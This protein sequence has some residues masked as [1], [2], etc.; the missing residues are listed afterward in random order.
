MTDFK[1]PE[2]RIYPGSGTEEFELEQE[3]DGERRMAAAL[4]GQISDRQ[5]RNADR[6]RGTIERRVAACVSVAGCTLGA[7]KTNDPE[8]YR[9][10]LRGCVRAIRRESAV[11]DGTLSLGDL[12]ELRRR[13]NVQRE[14]DRYAEEFPDFD[15]Y[16]D[17]VS[18]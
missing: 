3:R 12:A 1:F 14:T 16:G 8:R 7:L 17:R 5:N 18:P 2:I 11:A 10:F 6:Y 15:D 13:F 9:S 4:A